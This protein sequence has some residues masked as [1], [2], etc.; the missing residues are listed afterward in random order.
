MTFI[1]TAI[2]NLRSALA[3]TSTRATGAYITRLTAT[4]TFAYLLATLIPGTTE[5]PVLAPLTALLVL[6]A[7]LY[8]TIRSGLKKVL[9]VAVG[10][11]VAVGLAE[12]IGFSWW[13]LM[14]VIAA[15]LLIGRV[16]RLGDDLLEV[17]ISAM[18]IFAS[19]GS[20]AAAS[21]RVVDTLVGTAAGLIGGLA[22]APLR[23][24]PAREAVCG[25]TGR[26][27]A[28]LDRMAAD[29]AA[30]PE[31][32]PVTEWLTQARSLR[33]EI[34]R[35]DDAL[36]EAADSAR[37][38]PRALVGTAESV[39]VTEMTV[40]LRG[41]LEALE[42]AALTVRGLARS[43]LDG[44]RIDAAAN[45]VRDPATRARLADV[46]TQLGA[47]IRTYGALV[48]TMPA[49]SESLESELAA[50]LAETHRL[51]DRLADLLAPTPCPVA[52]T[53]TGHADAD[54]DGDRAADSIAGS[55]WPL[56][57]EILTHVDRLRTGLT[58]DSIPREHRQARPAPRPIRLRAPRLRPPEQFLAV[59]RSLG[60]HSL[61]TRSLGKP[62]SSV[63][64]RRG[65]RK[66]TVPRQRRAAQPIDR[67]RPSS[68]RC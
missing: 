59:T 67:G 51:Q 39:P 45:P 34:E 44:A 32:A 63:R 10:V 53:E 47:V 42:H 52:V 64:V 24:Q 16:L 48:Q 33:D 9:S 17:P 15:A 1:L 57:G 49:G 37:F 41:G 40:S 5:R 46:L 60:P 68:P 66:P 20:H 56:R 6:Q 23:V 11:L 30:E 38:N 13:Q 50:Q 58:A 43:V 22:F 61:G 8:Q 3:V 12:F 36:R 19:A 29:L 62:E 28:L 26:L 25:L 55:Q 31:P 21:G 2:R 4:A 54:A 18:L 14:L 35:V 65:A 27:A 7:S